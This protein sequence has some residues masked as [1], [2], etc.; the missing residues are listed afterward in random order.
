VPGGFATT[1]EAYRLF[2]SHNGLDQPLRQ[3]LSQLDSTDLGALQAAERAGPPTHLAAF[4]P[5]SLQQRSLRPTP[6]CRHNEVSG[7]ANP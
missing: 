3:L 2:L 5:E 7:M 6:I 4:L 1:S